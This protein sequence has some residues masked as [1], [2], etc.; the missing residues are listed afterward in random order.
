MS[1]EESLCSDKLET[2]KILENVERIRLLIIEN[3]CLTE[4]KKNPKNNLSQ[5]L[6]TRKFAAKFISL[7]C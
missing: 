4:T 3:Y 7:R 5:D 2:T 1:I 6:E